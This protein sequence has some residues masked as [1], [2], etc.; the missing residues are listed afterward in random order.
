MTKV[1][2]KY[3]IHLSIY[4][5]LHVSASFSPSSEA[6]V[7]L[8]QW[9]KSA[10][11]GVSSGVPRGGSNPPPPKFRRLDKA[12]PNSQFRGIYIH[13]NLIRIRVSFIC[14]SS[15]TPD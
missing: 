8:R 10:G 1:M 13:N 3:L 5:A 7:Q 2:H 9:F 14:K 12:E 15:G 4:S 11:F 6:G